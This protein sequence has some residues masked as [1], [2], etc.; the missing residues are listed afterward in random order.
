MSWRLSVLWILCLAKLTGSFS[1][2]MKKICFF[3]LIT[4]IFA[5]SIAKVSFAQTTCA[6]K[7]SVKSDKNLLVKGVTA[8]ATSY[9]TKKIYQAVLKDDL[10]YFAE[11]PKG[12]YEISLTKSGFKQSRG[13]VPV[14]CEST[15]DT[16]D[17]LMVEG[18]ER[19]FF[20]ITVRLKTQLLTAEE[21]RIMSS[22]SDFD[23]LKLSAKLKGI[24]NFDAVHL[25]KPVYPIAARR[26]NAAGVVTVQITVN[27]KG[28]VELAEAVEGNP[29]LH[30]AA[31]EAAKKA[32]FK[33]RIE[34][35]KPVKFKGKLVY[36]F[37][38][39]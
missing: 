24:L 3:F 23:R 27:E 32:K 17:A 5:A 2:F 28:K 25:A 36:S 9:E 4:I 29:L 22:G 35:G 14:P 13:G 37:V 26:V 12:G 11:I 20:D 8:T 19:E 31:V 21:Q 6:V 18:S 7:L 38:G 34:N 16:L 1:G 30:E 10:P 33:P 15:Y 39:R